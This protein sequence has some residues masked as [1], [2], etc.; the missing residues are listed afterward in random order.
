MNIIDLFG[1]LN[2]IQ[3]KL[4]EMFKSKPSQQ[5]AEEIAKMCNENGITKSDLV[6]L[7]NGLKGK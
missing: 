4:V 1:Q 7:I 5:Q 2:P 6:K 3:K